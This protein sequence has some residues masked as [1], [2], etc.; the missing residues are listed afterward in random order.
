MCGIAGA[1]NHPRAATLVAKMMDVLVHRGPDG[2]GL[3]RDHGCVAL[4]HRRLAIIDL[5]ERAS[6]P[7][8]SVD[9][10]F[11]LVYNGEIYNF[12]ELR[13]EL[14]SR[15][16]IRFQSDSDTEVLLQGFA[17]WGPAVLTRLNGMFAFALFDRHE[18]KLYLAR[19]RIGVKPLYWARVGS[20]ILF[21]SEMKALLACEEVS[22]ELS[23]SGVRDFLHVGYVPGPAT[24]LSGV[25]KVAPASIMTIKLTGE[26]DESRYWSVLDSF[27]APP[28]AR[29]LDDVVDELEPL[30]ADAFN[31]RMISDVPVGIYLSAGVDSSLLAAS[32]V[33][34]GASP[35]AFTLAVRER[36]FD[37]SS[38][39]A[40]TARALGI[41]HVI[42]EMSIDDIKRQI[43]LLPAAYDEPLADT[44]ALPTL[45]ISRAAARH[46]KVVLSADGGDELFG[47][48][49]RYRWA[50]SV[51]A[52][53][54]IVPH[55][56]LRDLARYVSGQIDT[57]KLFRSRSGSGA[58]WKTARNVHKL[59]DVLAGGDMVARYREWNAIAG[60]ARLRLLFPD[61][62]ET[63]DGDA[64]Q[65]TC[66][67]GVL[68]ACAINDIVTYLPDD[69]LMKV[70]R[71]TMAA[72][73]EGRDPFLDHRIVEFCGRLPPDYRLRGG[74]GK[75]LLKALLRRYGLHGPAQGRK[76]GFSM[77]ITRW[78]SQDWGAL[79][80]EY[81]RRDRL[82][83]LPG[84]DV[85]AAMA[86]HERFQSGDRA[87]TGLM[88]AL[89][90]LS[91]WRAQWGV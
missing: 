56:T 83:D 28:T 37:E 62:A 12:A 59:A 1:I 67:R 29:P 61:H 72:S 22:K 5:S 73:M 82:V 86:L 87:L 63:D 76:R 53:L 35:R 85:Q 18:E 49:R 65:M 36:G 40:A 47:G 66:A 58:A 74:S 16:G 7:M 45:A 39:A 77:P 25:R 43:Q 21:A 91:M 8:R 23:P 68:E 17:V 50:A 15:H 89:L 75:V 30:L 78:L 24:V 44:S 6:Q 60:A 57:N 2:S 14:E 46:V 52:L 55:T 81:L 10:R 4:G 13:Q 84:L 48:Y 54:R 19:D 3:W 70:D 27:A 69:I 32:L 51:E 79:L 38:E 71:A 34:Q 64:I 42:E 88:Y 31:K 90:C 80:A 9:G 20:A 41:D 26:I 11:V 33:R